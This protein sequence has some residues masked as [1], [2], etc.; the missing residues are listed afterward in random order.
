MLNSTLRVVLATLLV[1]SSGLVATSALAS[2][3][4]NP[5]PV[6]YGCGDEGHDDKDKDD[7]FTLCG[8]EGHDDKDKDDSFTLCGDE[9]HDDK[10]KDES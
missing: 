4:T 2:Q 6:S 9:G 10:D 5:Q 1:G 8:D 3:A 7:S